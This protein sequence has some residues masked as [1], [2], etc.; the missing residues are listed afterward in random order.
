MSEY[1]LTSRRCWARFLIVAWLLLPLITASPAFGG[2]KVAELRCEWLVNPAGIDATQPR[3]GW[4]LKTDERAQSQYAYQ[5]LVAS[6][7]SKLKVGKA[8]LWDSGQV[9]SSQSVLV[10]YGG[11]ALKS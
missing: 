3:L 6:T 4:V 5:I 8:D 2:M 7:E 9:I 11:K 1:I 10:P